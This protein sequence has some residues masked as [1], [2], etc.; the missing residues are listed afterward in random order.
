MEGIYNFTK[1]INIFTRCAYAP[2][3]YNLWIRHWC[4][5]S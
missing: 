3:P 1:G 2:C 5:V 4:H